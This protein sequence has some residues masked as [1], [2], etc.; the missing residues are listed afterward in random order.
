[1]NAGALVLAMIRDWI[2]GLLARLFGRPG[3]S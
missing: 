2:K 1:L 3:G